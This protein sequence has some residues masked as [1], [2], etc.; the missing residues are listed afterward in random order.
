MQITESMLRS[1]DEQ[2]VNEAMT[3]CQLKLEGVC[4][5]K[6]CKNA[7]KCFDS[8]NGLHQ[9]YMHSFKKL[10]NAI[11]ELNKRQIR[12]E[13]VTVKIIQLLNILIKKTDKIEALEKEIIDLKKDKV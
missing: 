7:G 3:K 1:E 6:F 13:D 5:G 4:R 12:D 2:E 10:D 9:F 11:G 8:P